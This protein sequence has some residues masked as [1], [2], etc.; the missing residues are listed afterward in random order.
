MPAATASVPGGSLWSSA[1]SILTKPRLSSFVTEV[2]Y[3]VTGANDD[4]AIIQTTRFIGIV[5]HRRNFVSYLAEHG[6]GT[7]PYRSFF[8]TWYS[9]MA[10]GSIRQ[11]GETHMDNLMD[12]RRERLENLL[13]HHSTTDLQKLLGVGEDFLED[14]L[15]GGD[16][17]WP[18]EATEKLNWLFFLTATRHVLKW[19]RLNQARTPL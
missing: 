11:Q 4:S 3:Q 15:A 6:S 13:Q 16:S 18:A 12:T 10:R 19:A 8:T 14:V 1:A 17:A 7:R 2:N 5:T 9:Y